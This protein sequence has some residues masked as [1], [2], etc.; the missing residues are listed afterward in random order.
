MKPYPDLATLLESGPQSG[1]L[2]RVHRSWRAEISNMLLFACSVIAV[3]MLNIYFR[4]FK[5][6]E[7]SPLSGILS[8]RWLS[9]IPAM[10]LIEMVRKFHDDLYVFELHRIACYEGRLSLTYQVPNLRY[11]DIKAIVLNQGFIGRV[12]DYGDIELSSAATSSTELS[13]C[14]VRSPRKLAKLI[15]ELRLH[16]QV[17]E[18]KLAEN[19]PQTVARKVVNL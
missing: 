3:V 16:S 5:A 18:K 11:S 10:L 9:I 8:T 15:E 19:T 13:L 7:G 2:L 1:E 6:P 12:F 4:D 14:G 17:M